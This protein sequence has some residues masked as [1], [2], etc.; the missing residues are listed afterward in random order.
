MIVLTNIEASVKIEKR[1]TQES[2]ANWLKGNFVLRKDDR[3]V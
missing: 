2:W 3:D 1:V